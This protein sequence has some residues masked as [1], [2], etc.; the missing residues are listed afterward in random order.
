MK[1]EFT[2][3]IWEIRNKNGNMFVQVSDSRKDKD[4]KWATN[5]RF[6]ASVHKDIADAVD[7]FEL[8][9]F[10]HAT[11]YEEKRGLKKGDGSYCE[12]Y[13]NFLTCDLVEREDNTDTNKG[14]KSRSYKRS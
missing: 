11:G 5:N 10:V 3:R 1:I 9:A 13:I 7:K 2:G 6:W 12:G 8:P 4:G 14:Y